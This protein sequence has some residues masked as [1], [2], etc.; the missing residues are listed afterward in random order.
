MA[1]KRDY[2]IHNAVV[3]TVDTADSVHS[4]VLMREGKIFMTGSDNEVIAGA[5]PDAELFDAGDAQLCRG[6][7]IRTNTRAW[8]PSRETPP[9]ARRRRSPRSM[10]CWRRSKSIARTCQGVGW[11]DNRQ[12]RVAT[13]EAKPAFVSLAKSN[14]GRIAT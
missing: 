5:N 6:S 2:I 9:T 8:L 7:S 13:A 4:A 1:Q 10:K 11:S 12:D 14:Q 3:R